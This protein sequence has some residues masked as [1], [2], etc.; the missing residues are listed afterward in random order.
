[1][2]RSEIHNIRKSLFATTVRGLHII[3]LTSILSGVGL[4][5]AS[6]NF[7][8]ANDKYTL[9]SVVEVCTMHA[10]LHQSN[11][12][13]L[14][15]T[16]CR[17]KRLE[18]L[19]KR[20]NLIPHGTALAKQLL[21]RAMQYALIAVCLVILAL[22]TFF[23]ITL[24]TLSLRLALGCRSVARITV[25]NI[26]I[27]LADLTT[28]QKVNYMWYE[29][30]QLVVRANVSAELPGVSVNV[31]ALKLNLDFNGLS[32]LRALHSTS[33][34]DIILPHDAP[35]NARRAKYATNRWEDGFDGRKQHALPGTA[36]LRAVTFHISH[37][38]IAVDPTK[39][40]AS[41]YMLSKEVCNQVNSRAGTD[42]RDMKERGE[43]I[44]VLVVLEH[45]NLSVHNVV[46]GH[47][48]EMVVHGV[49]Y[50]HSAVSGSVLDSGDVLVSQA[51]SG[52]VPERRSPLRSEHL[53]AVAEVSVYHHCHHSSQQ[54]HSRYDAVKRGNGIGAARQHAQGA[55][56]GSASGS[57][58]GE[59]VAYASGIQ[60]VLRS[61]AVSSPSPSP[62]LRSAYDA[63]FRLQRLVLTPPEHSGERCAGRGNTEATRTGYEEVQGSGMLWAKLG[64]LLLYRRLVPL[65]TA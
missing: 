57:S 49:Q 41:L 28:T 40:P 20:L 61:R 60:G 16:R 53:V 52:D 21:D 36:V 34:C 25:S 39:I 2:L 4:E 15:D 17:M 10:S 18:W 22:L 38:D 62:S 43:I 45:G 35:D 48:Q 42:T 30:F 37:L 31:E 5:H 9:D 54:P 50:K 24:P 64:E 11:Q 56:G 26:R 29:S 63:A 23:D 33:F 47:S 32:L 12:G 65:L 27:S 6:P 55:R 3:L 44:P 58:S 1:M 8:I 51:G 19:V 59:R 7:E 46:R 14:G 13:D